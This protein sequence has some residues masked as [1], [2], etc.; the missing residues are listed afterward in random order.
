MN[1]TLKGGTVT[2]PTFRAALVVAVFAAAGLAA[3]AQSPTS[4]DALIKRIQALEKRVDDLEKD[5]G[6]FEVGGGGEKPKGG[7]GAGTGTGGGA[8]GTSEPLVPPSASDGPLTGQVT[9]VKAPFEVVDS[10]GRPILRVREE[11]DA[12][13]RGLYVLNQSGNT[14]ASMGAFSNGGIVVARDG[15]QGGKVGALMASAQGSGMV[16]QSA[17]GQES[18]LVDGRNSRIALMNNSGVSTVELVTG[19][20]GRL[21]LRDGS[22][23]NVVEAGSLPSGV[24]IVRAGPRMGGAVGL[25]GLPFAVMGKK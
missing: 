9:R 4:V 20:T 1:T 3:S 17:G 14:L 18:V 12:A 11:A 25:Q 15:T 16:V 19:V 8:R 10:A 21:I 22:G 2:Y 13:S 7:G 23:N 6:A 24:G 5:G